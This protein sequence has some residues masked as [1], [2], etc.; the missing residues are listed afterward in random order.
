[1]KII[2]A[3]QQGAAMIYLADL[4][5]FLR[6]E[7]GGYD[8]EGMEDIINLAEIIG[9]EDLAKYFRSEEEDER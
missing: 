2:T 3:R 6:D 7:D 5:G 1:M 4:L 9:G 8:S